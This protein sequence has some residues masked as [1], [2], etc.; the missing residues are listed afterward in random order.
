MLKSLDANADAWIY[1]GKWYRDG[2]PDKRS[3]AAGKEKWVKVV[4]RDPG[5][6]MEWDG[7]PGG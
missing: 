1:A 7:T 6:G 2:G 4:V 3:D 5:Y